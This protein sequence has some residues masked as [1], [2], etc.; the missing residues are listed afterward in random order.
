ML[1]MCVCVC[2]R[3]R[4]RVR[5]CMCVCACGERAL[6]FHWLLETRALFEIGHYSREGSNRASTVFEVL[7][8]SSVLTCAYMRVC[9]CA[10]VCVCMCVCV[11]ACMRVHLH[12]V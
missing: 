1:Q 3:V 4:V 8:K 10:C 12:I 5:V 11:C 2:V 6:F 9:V 7:T